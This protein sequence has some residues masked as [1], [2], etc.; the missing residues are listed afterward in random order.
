MIDEQATRIV[1]RM[2]VCI[3]HL[4]SRRAAEEG[5]AW[6]CR[7]CKQAYDMEAIEQRMVVALNQHVRAYELQVCV[8][9]VF[10]ARQLAS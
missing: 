4:N 9:A 10:Q 2:N 7:Q 1:M 3:Q 6:S 5:D 8:V